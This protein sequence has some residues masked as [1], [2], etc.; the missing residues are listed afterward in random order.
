MG[1][2]GRFGKYGENKRFERLRSGRIGAISSSKPII[3]SFRSHPVS[4]RSLYQEAR[5][6]LRPANNKDIQFIRRLSAKVFNIYGPYE[7]IIP[8]WF[9]SDISVTIIALMNRQPA[10]FAMIGDP[11]I[12]YDFQH[13]SEL[14]A[15]AVDPKRQRKGIGKLL[16]G[17]MDKKAIE[18]NIKRIF[19]HTAKENLPAQRLFA[20]AGYKPWEI[21]KGF[22]P[23]GQD[24]IVMFRMPG[25]LF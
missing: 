23:K 5:V 24:A 20:R 2:R 6:N 14:L 4:E 21:K 13:V 9:E 11:S 1:N 15:I 19:L 16:L 3:K 18:L 17:E 22:Y 8:K 12:R 7:E 25:K 10:G